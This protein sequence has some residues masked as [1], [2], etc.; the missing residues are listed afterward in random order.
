MALVIYLSLRII[1]SL[2]SCLSTRLISTCYL[3]LNFAIMVIDAHLLVMNLRLLHL[4]G[5][6]L[7]LRVFGMKVYI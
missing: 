4:M 7:S 5:K 1:I 3:L 6:T 2:M